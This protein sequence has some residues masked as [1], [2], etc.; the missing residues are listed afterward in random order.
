MNRFREKLLE[1]EAWQFN[2]DDRDAWP[3]WVKG[4]P[5]TAIHYAAV[6][7]EP[8]QLSITSEEGEMRADIGDWLVR[9]PEGKVS[10]VKADAFPALYEPVSG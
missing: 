5:Y 9:D 10:I 4:H 2:G 8:Y 7:P 3:E 1:I 6:A